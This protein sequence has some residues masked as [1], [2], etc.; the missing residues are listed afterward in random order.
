MLFWV[1]K[2][3]TIILHSEISSIIDRLSSPNK[4]KT[5]EKSVLKGKMAVSPLDL[6]E[7]QVIDG[8]RSNFIEELQTITDIDAQNVSEPTEVCDVNKYREMIP[9]NTAD[10]KKISQQESILELLIT[11]GICDDETFKYF[12]AEPGSHKEEASKI[13]DS[14]YCVNTTMPESY[15]NEMSS[16]WNNTIQTV[17]CLIGT[18]ND[19][20]PSERITFQIVTDSSN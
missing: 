12:I 13:L 19:A 3:D 6:N 10:P 11:N 17:P 20:I 18:E 7:V 9:Y 4:K 5:Q 15:E 14:L 1:T 2:I 8:G 16:G